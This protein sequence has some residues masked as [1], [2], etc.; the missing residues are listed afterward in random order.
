MIFNVLV[1]KKNSEEKQNALGQEIVT[2]LKNMGCHPEK[3]LYKNFKVT[4]GIKSIGHGQYGFVYMGY[5]NKEATK[6]IAIKIS[7]GSMQ[8]EY[9]IMQELKG[10]GIARAYA[11]EKCPEHQVMYLQ[12]ANKGSLDTFTVTSTIIQSIVAQVIYKLYRIHMK[13]P[14]FRHNDLHTGNI[15]VDRRND[16]YHAMLGDFGLSC[17]KS[18]V[19]SLV[20]LGVLKS[21]GVYLNAPVM[22]DVHFFLSSIHATFG[23]VP[24]IKKFIGDIFPPE[25]LEKTN[26]KMVMY[27]MRANVDHS[28]F[29]SYETI[30]KHPFF[31]AFRIRKSVA[32]T[33]KAPTQ[34]HINMVALAKKMAVAP[35]PAPAPAPAL[36]PV[37]P[38]NTRFSL[39]KNGDLKIMKKKCRL[40]KKPELIAL[41]KNA[42]IS[43]NKGTVQNICAALQKKY[44][45][46]V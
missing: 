32:P 3:V 42:G 46:T 7:K 18:H 21:Q 10:M 25:Y 37:P 41:A 44:I 36:P 6:S 8:N 40:M 13:I 1:N 20:K 35:A 24:E 9:N 19:N 4:K 30:F 34:A 11:L 26:D 22:Y 33:K 23:K 16:G 31:D 45:A 28:A 43:V 14:T 29:P 2:A 15:L 12:Y 27:R 17:T 5:I 38:K 39:N